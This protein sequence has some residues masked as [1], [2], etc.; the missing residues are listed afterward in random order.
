MNK[1][2][3][4]LSILALTAC[5]GGGSSPATPTQADPPAPET[6]LSGIFID[7]PVSNIDYRTAT[8]QGQTDQSGVF[9]YETDESVEFS[10]GALIIG[11]AIGADQ[12]TPLI[13]APE[14]SIESNY[15]VNL[16][17][18]LQTLDVDGDPS[19]G[20]SIADA[21][22]ES[23]VQI[24]FSQTQDAFAA[25]PEVLALIAAGGQT[26]AVT[27]L[28]SKQDSLQ[29]FAE[30]LLAQGNIVVSKDSDGDGI[31]DVADLDDDGDGV[32][33]ASDAFPL[34]KAESVDTDS[35]G[36]GNNADTD[37][38]GDGVPD[39]SDAFPL[40]KA[41]LVDTD[42]D[43]TGNIA[44]T[45]DDGD[46]VA[47]ASDAF[48]LDKTET[49]DTDG[50][51]TGNNADADDDGDGVADTSDAFPLVKTESLDTDGDGTGN[52]ADTDDDNDGILDTAD[53]YPLV[54]G[55]NV[56]PVFDL[57]STCF[58]VPE[59]SLAVCAIAATDADS[60]SLTFTITGG[61]DASDF[62]LKVGNNLV[63]VSPPDYESPVDNEQN[64]TYI[65]IVTV[66]DGFTTVTHTMTIN[67]TDV[68]ENV[69]GES[70]FGQGKFQ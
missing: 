64:N 30:S 13:L 57:S 43:G 47:D 20:I 44:D 69:L 41:E 18:L 56:D 9:L 67:V 68:E 65:V 63:F 51:G 24:D 23:A 4:I 19:N 2:L 59:N 52:N 39:T 27:A 33:D 21:A 25:S 22:K 55:S 45:D 17:R 70:K 50:D 11:S 5:G 35:D 7:S 37:D 46:G 29:H 61:A 6:P 1:V 60:D 31:F 53:R 14:S 16:V 8:R 28:R 38:D 49:L 3:P 58:S 40:D 54:A 26:T 32:P 34:D 12:I 48:P 42:G 62:Q 15:V 66:A 36:T 10:L